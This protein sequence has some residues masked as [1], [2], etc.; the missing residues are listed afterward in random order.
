[1]NFGYYAF[2][3]MLTSGFLRCSRASDR[4]PLEVNCAGHVGLG[5]PF[6][7][8]MPGGRED[9][10]LLYIV[11][12]EL[13]VSL[14]QG[15]RTVSTGY[16]AI[17]PPRF[18]YIYHYRAQGEELE[19]FWVHFTGSYVKDLLQVCGMDSFPFLCDCGDH[20]GIPALFS[21]LFETFEKNS[22]L[23]IPLRSCLLE[24]ILLA[25]AQPSE[26]I[27]KEPALARSIRYI[28]SSYHTDIRIPELAKMENISHS[29]YIVLFKKRYG[30]S[31]TAYIV[32][33]RLNIACDFL[34]T[35]DMSVKQIAS[36]VGYED[37]HFF[38]KLFKRHVG[39]SPQQYRKT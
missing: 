20:T 23:C 2:S 14:P 18:H 22:A 29:H 9:Y 28:H 30:L 3:D 1:M 11:K 4:L 36:S 38:S 16:A 8:D 31:P 12:G 27:P 5:T 19:Y 32:N 17:F 25:I 33:L 15:S 10:Y 21:M 34:K 37:P 13:D 6:T 7:T 26:H 24:Q 39:V 35:T